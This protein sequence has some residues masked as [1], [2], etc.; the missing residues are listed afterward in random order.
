MAQEI[1]LSALLERWKKD[2]GIKVLCAE[3]LRDTEAYRKIG[4]VQDREERVELRK[5]WTAMSDR[6]WVLLK[7]I[8]MVMAKEGPE[9]LSFGPKERLLLDG[10]FLSPG[11]TSFNEALPT[12][13]SQDRPQ[14][15][16]QY[17]TFTEY[18][19]DFYAGLYNKEKRSGIDVFGDRMKDYKASTDTAMKRASLSLKTILPQVP[20][21]TKEKAE[22]LVGKLE[23]NLEPFLERHMRTRK[24]R[25]M[26]KKQCDETIERSNFFS[27]ARNEVESLITKASK[28]IDGF[29]DDE[30]RRFKGL[31]D[32]VVFFG[33]V[34]IH[35]RNEAD[36][37]DR[38][39]DR[40][41][42]KFA[43][44]SEGD[45]LVRLEE[46]IKGK[47][48]MAG[49]MARIART[50]TSPLCQQSVQKPMTFQ[51]VSEILKRLVHLDEDMLR[52]PRVRMYGIPRVVIVP[53]QGY[54]AYDW[55]DN[56]FIMP[57]FPSHSAEK[58]VAYSLASF[59]WD[60]D[61]DREFK[62]TYELL[63]ENKGK[64]IKGLASSFSNDYYLW[65]TKERYGFRV[66]PRE[67]R[68]WFKTKFDSEGVR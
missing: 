28:T 7:S 58:A 40:N 2:E 43:T 51:E 38:T 18:W 14:D 44:E 30:R 36:R 42:A 68:D 6:Y 9:A 26:E 13:L 39:R 62:N 25:E 57:L 66:L 23:K 31:V 37:W 11:V 12:W 59:R 1:V 10:G 17:M 15:M 8:L 33:S 65:L 41:A 4:D 52:V 67:V 3:Y 56:S 54:G 5:L 19:Q 24:F 50:D 55:T 29:G 27:F 20:D 34:Y 22:E 53:G 64:S 45:R 35:I 47:G 63:K 60:A 48:E 49:Q 61:E 32:D 21:C 46:A 16:F